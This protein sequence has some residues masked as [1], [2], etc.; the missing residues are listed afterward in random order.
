VARRSMRRSRVKPDTYTL[1]AVLTAAAKNG[2]IKL[3]ELDALMAHFEGAGVMRNV[4]VSAALVQAYRTC[5]HIGAGERIARAEAERALMKARGIA[6]NSQFLTIVVSLYWDCLDYAGA[7]RAYD[8]LVAQGVGPHEPTYEMMRLLN[9]EA[10]H[11]D[12][13]RQF[14]ELRRL[15]AELNGSA[16]ERRGGRRWREYDLLGDDFDPGG[17]FTKYG[18]TDNTAIR[19]ANEE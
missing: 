16:V 7:N 5:Q 12:L 6:P 8:S 2:Y 15:V 18:P 3:A 4:V 10:G 13:A 17:I 19:Q 9:V 11:D 14:E 1:V